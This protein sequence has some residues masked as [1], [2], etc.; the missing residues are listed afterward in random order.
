M[1]VR[2]H[3]P[4][5]DKPCFQLLNHT[6]SGGILYRQTLQCIF[7]TNLHVHQCFSF[8][9]MHTIL[10]LICSASSIKRFS[11]LFQIMVVFCGPEEKN[12]A[13]AKTILINIPNKESMHQIS[14]LGGKMTYFARSESKLWEVEVD[15]LS[16]RFH[17][18]MLISS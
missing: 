16:M 12:T 1:I 8:Q 4:C 10:C 18:L 13:K 11:L 15:F 3:K 2:N 6:D 9:F 14:V 17:I 5:I 7:K